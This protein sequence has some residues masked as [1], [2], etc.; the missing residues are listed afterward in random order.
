MAHQNGGTLPWHG[1]EQCTPCDDSGSSAAST[2]SAAST[3]S[4]ECSGSPR[5]GSGSWSNS[6]GEDALLWMDM[7]TTGLSPDATDTAGTPAACII[8]VA[9]VLTNAAGAPMYEGHWVLRP[10]S[11]GHLHGA[12]QWC[13]QRFGRSRG[14]PYTAPTTTG[15][16]ARVSRASAPW[17]WDSLFG[18]ALASTVTPQ[19]VDVTLCSWLQAVGCSKVCLAGKSIKLEW[20]FLKAHMPGTFERLHY[21]TLDVSDV[22]NSLGCLL[23]GARGIRRV[24]QASPSRPG[25]H[26]AARDLQATMHLHAWLCTT[27]FSGVHH[28]LLK[29][30]L[31]GMQPRVRGAVGGEYRGKPPGRSSVGHGD[32]EGTSTPKRSTTIRQ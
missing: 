13:K 16:A 29:E 9:A 6:V 27:L 26:C 3:A 2:D 22:M 25:D 4:P 8:E 21:T 7:E 17:P 20:E 15:S 5:G 1:A 30:E 23:G 24:L 18:E 10:P 12:S 11:V 19:D 14:R 28:Q 31:A 32:W